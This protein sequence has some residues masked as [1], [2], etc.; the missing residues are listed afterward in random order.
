M[1]LTFH[2]IVV[3]SAWSIVTAAAVDAVEK[4]YLTPEERA[5]IAEL[6]LART[7]PREYAKLVE[8]WVEYY[9]GTLRE[10]PDR[11]P[12]RTK[13]GVKA[14]HEAISFLERQ[15][16]MHAL[17]PA[18]GL[19]HGARDHVGDMGP[20]GATGHTGYDDSHVGDRVNRYGRWKGKVAENIAYGSEDPREIVMRLIIDDGVESR[21][22]R[23]NIFDPEFHIVGVAMGYHDVFAT[24]CVITFAADYLE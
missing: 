21:G 24:M 14:L 4:D 1:R 16:P 2:T 19:A 12:V 22:H 10:L 6:N 5:V 3:L 8:Q 15:S 18:R 7:K 23:K 13:E 11:I 20:S 9:D 17:E